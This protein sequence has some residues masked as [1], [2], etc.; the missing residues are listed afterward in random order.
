MD[1]AGLAASGSI[2][3]KALPRKTVGKSSIAPATGQLDAAI[4]NRNYG[5]SRA[6][7][8]RV[9]PTPI[10]LQPVNMHFAFPANKPAIESL[11]IE[12]DALLQQQ[13]EDTLYGT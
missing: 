5:D 8:Y 11:R 4:T 6:G 10:M 3:S 9:A 7:Q 1:R 12:L 13:V 2:F